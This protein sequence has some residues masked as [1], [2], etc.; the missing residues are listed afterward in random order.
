MVFN[1]KTMLITIVNQHQIFEK[2][3]FQSLTLML[4]KI[5]KND[6]LIQY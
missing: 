5:S 2:H 6:N 1:V 4:T 3:K